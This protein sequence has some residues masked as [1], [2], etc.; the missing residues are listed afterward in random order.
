MATFWFPAA[1]KAGD[2]PSLL[3]NRTLA[4]TFVTYPVDPRLAYFRCLAFE[5]RS[6]A[7][8]EASYPIVIYSCGGGNFRRDNTLLALAL[9]SHGYIVVSV[10]HEDLSF[11]ELPDG[12]IGSGTLPE[13][14]PGVPESSRALLFHGENSRFVNSHN[15][16]GEPRQ[17]ASA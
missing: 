13:E 14:L 3:F 5:G 9:A 12:Q 16:P 7:T 15:G 1:P 10:D 6:L 17:P 4:R 2:L 11:A 8:N